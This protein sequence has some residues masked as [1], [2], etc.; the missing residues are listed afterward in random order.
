MLC[1]FAIQVANLHN[2]FVTIV[3][4][5]AM[6]SQH[7][8]EHGYLRQFIQRRG[9][10]EDLGSHLRLKIATRSFFWSSP[11]GDKLTNSMTKSPV[12]STASLK[13]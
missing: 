6:S 4:Y 8:Q 10:A 1:R 13:E 2:C 7:T 11:D 12:M 5:A 3:G 9:Y